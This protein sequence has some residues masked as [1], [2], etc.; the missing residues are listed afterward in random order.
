MPSS[1]FTRQANFAGLAKSLRSLARVL[2][3]QMTVI[4]QR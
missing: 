3:E 1:V 2:R 4:Q